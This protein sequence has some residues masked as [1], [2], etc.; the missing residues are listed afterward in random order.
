[1]GYSHFSSGDLFRAIGKERGL[2][3]HQANLAAEQKEKEIDHIVDKK[4][5]DIGATQDN[6]VID[7]RMAWHWM[8]SSFKVFLDLDLEVAATRIIE[9]MDESRLDN[10]HIPHN[11][12]EYA[13]ILQQ[14]LDSESR[15]YKNLYNANPYNKSNYDFVIDTEAHSPDQVAQQLVDA[16]NKWLG[17]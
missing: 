5:Q 8:P 6:L 1:M 4:L 17:N 7:S 10:E 9:S 14:R 15:R 12:K 2:E 16:F 3:L 13:E 11:P